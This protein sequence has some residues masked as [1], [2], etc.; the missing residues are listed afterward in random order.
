MNGYILTVLITLGLSALLCAAVIK[1]YRRQTESTL[2]NLLQALDGAVGGVL[3]GT[4]YDESL[5]AAVRERLSR[6]VQ[7]SVMQRDSAKEERDVIKA[8]ISDISHQVRTPLTNI[9]LYTGLL[10]EQSLGKDAAALADKIDRQTEK[11]DFFMKELVKSSYTEQAMIS[12]CP[13]MIDVEEVIDTAC[14]MT[15]LAAMKKNIDMRVEKKETVCC[16]D[17]KWTTEALGNV[18][19][20]AV[21]YSP[22]HSVIRI[23]TV[24]YESFV[25]IRVQDEGIGIG[26]EEQGRVFERFYRS[27]SVKGEPGF[28][29]GLYL[30]RAVLSK[31][32]GYARIKSRPGSGT[33]VELYLARTKV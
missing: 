30:V 8:L 3:P 7:I 25:C 18:L 31:Q 14:Q 23:T 27:D 20:N 11:L 19:E 13:Q 12:V 17:K 22:E 26:E 32:G 6:V 1:H 28:G 4:S 5:D 15:E 33:T 24:L 16:A 9:M 2:D 21:K 29:I 10:R